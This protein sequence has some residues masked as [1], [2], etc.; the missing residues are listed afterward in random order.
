M[1]PEF[2]I[3]DR[4]HIKTMSTGSPAFF[5]PAPRLRLARF[6]RLFS[7]SARSTGASSQA[8]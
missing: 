4:R 7:L 8:S 1:I 6:T 3:M 5:L 2:G